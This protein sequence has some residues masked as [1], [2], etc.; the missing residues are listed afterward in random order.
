MQQNICWVTK[1]HIRA[2]AAQCPSG[3]GVVSAVKGAKDVA[4][5]TGEDAMLA[6]SIGATAMSNCAG[7]ESYERRDGL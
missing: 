2:R 5:Q 3:E 7:W 1:C 6:M 4:Q